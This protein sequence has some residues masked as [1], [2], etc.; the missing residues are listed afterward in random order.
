[1]AQPHE[2]RAESLIPR[3]ATI[4]TRMSNPLPTAATA[5]TLL[6]AELLKK[7]SM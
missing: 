4:R 7:V 5:Y 1:M 3:A 2:N 6:A